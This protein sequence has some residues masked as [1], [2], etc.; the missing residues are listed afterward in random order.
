LSSILIPGSVWRHP[1]EDATFDGFDA[2]LIYANARGD[3]MADGKIRMSAERLDVAAEP[4]SLPTV[5]FLTTTLSEFRISLDAT[6]LD[7]GTA[8]IPFELALWSPLTQS[9]SELIFRGS[10][11]IVVNT[12]RGGR[13]AHTL[14]GGT[15]TRSEDAGFFQRE[16]PTHVAITVRKKGGTSHI[17]IANRVGTSV[18]NVSASELADLFASPR[19]SLTGSFEPGDTSSSTRLDNYKVTLYHEVFWINRSDDPTA[20]SLLIVT[21]ALGILVLAFLASRVG[22]ERYTSGRSRPRRS[23]VIRSGLLLIMALGVAA[24]VLPNLLLVKLGAH[25]FDMS[26]ERL[27]SYVA[28]RFGLPD[29]YY[30]PNIV[31]FP[32]IWGGT[33]YGSA[34]FPYEPV[35]AYYFSALGSFGGSWYDG[36][37]GLS[38]S[39]LPIDY[40][41]KSANVLFAMLDGALIYLICRR[42]GTG[43]AWSIG[44]TCF[45]LLNPAVLFSTSVWGQTHVVSLAFV[46][47]AVYLAERNLAFPAWLALGLGVLTRPQI[48]VFGLILGL[49]FIL[50]FRWQVNV[51]AA[52][53]A[54]IVVFL[55]L[56]PFTLATGPS[57]P[58][59]VLVNTL[60]L[61]LHSSAADPSTLSQDA[62]SI[63]P[64]VSYLQYGASGLARSFTPSNQTLLGSVTYQG[65][66]TI[67]AIL[68]LLAVAILLVV[69]GRKGV[70]M[71]Q[72]IPVVTLSIVGF[73][74][75]TTGLVATH[76]VLALPFLILCRRWMNNGA[77]FFVIIVWTITTLV[78]MYGDMG[79]VIARLDYPLL[80]PLH[81]GVTR[82]FVELYS[83]DRFITFATLANIAVLIWIAVVALRPKSQP[84]L[85]DATT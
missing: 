38:S 8:A 10:G 12:V 19:L 13:S 26:N 65:A 40:L 9:G 69:R 52:S 42:F 6:V 54:V 41:I 39:V 11:P 43:R 34:A 44:A 84:D 24:Y 45:F 62:Y 50:K 75:L 57:L 37:Q 29:L 33:P 70:A 67:A 59:D 25:P 18:I 73:L 48:L 71:G 76:F 77:F 20:L 36:Q 47:A 68:T 51:R 46:L 64:L 23:T 60:S 3:G 53:A 17:D 82:F 35:L 15:V 56:L 58:M 28:N 80:S 81:N 22:V 61:Q 30:A 21:G 32:A 2:H 5:N 66:A 27:Y 4:R 14:Q 83:W 7:T 85:M 31:G 49:V 79:N 1:S 63:W 72:Y 78:P 55:I 16:V 74:M